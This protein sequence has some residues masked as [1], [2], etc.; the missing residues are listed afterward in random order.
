MKPILL[1]LRRSRAG[2]A[3][4]LL[5]TLVFTA[6]CATT[7][8]LPDYVSRPKDGFAVLVGPVSGTGPRSFVIAAPKALSV[9]LTCAGHRIAWL[10]TVPDVVGMGVQCASGGATGSDWVNMPAKDVG[11]IVHVRITAAAGTRW[12]LR[13][14]GSSNIH[15][16]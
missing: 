6:A 16:T 4:V 5:L 13:V 3:I 14:D 1:D 12:L 9:T 10:R 8:K 7:L 15:P 11:R 2:I